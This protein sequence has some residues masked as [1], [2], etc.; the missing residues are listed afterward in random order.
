MERNLGLSAWRTHAVRGKV[1]RQVVDALHVL[2]DP[3]IFAAR[4]PRN[5]CAIFHPNS[6]ESSDES[7]LRAARITANI[8]PGQAT[9]SP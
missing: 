1:G 8:Q 4:L 2:H 5:E 3:S 6:L 7:A 9:E